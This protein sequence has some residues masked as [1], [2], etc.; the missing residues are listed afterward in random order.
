MKIKCLYCD[1]QKFDSQCGSVEHV[2]LSAIGGKKTSQNICC[3]SCNQRLGNEIDE[4][5]AKGIGILATLYGIKTGRGKSAA[6]IRNAGDHSGG[7]FDLLPNGKMAPSKKVKIERNINKTTGEGNIAISASTEEEVLRLLKEQLNS[8][9]KDMSNFNMKSFVKKT[10]YPGEI[11]GNLDVGLITQHR[12]I[13]KTALTYLATMINPGRLRSESFTTIVNCINGVEDI[14]K[15]FSITTLNFPDLP[16]ISILQHRVIISASSLNRK[17]IGLVEL[18]SGIKFKV[19][20]TN[21]WDGPDFQKG[22]AVDPISGT[23]TEEDMKVDLNDSHW[24]DAQITDDKHYEIMVNT[25]NKAINY[26]RTFSFNEMIDNQLLS[27]V[28]ENQGKELTE[29][30]RQSLYARVATAISDGMFRNNRT[31]DIAPEL[32]K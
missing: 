2:L 26:Q 14:T 1:I 6:I 11:S 19:I 10:E 9:G 17:V 22:Y 4:P 28:E 24:D 25:F 7:S 29:E 23:H 16:S 20:L 21:T 12:S 15:Y 5:L 27:F 3:V 32:L 18:Y 31:I 8:V 13:A 30:L